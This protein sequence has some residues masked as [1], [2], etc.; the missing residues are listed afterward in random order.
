MRRGNAFPGPLASTDP[1]SQ[2]SL[3]QFITGAYAG[4]RGDPMYVHS[5][6]TLAGLVLAGA[7]VIQGCQC[8][9]SQARRNYGEIG[10]V[11][12]D[13]RDNV[14][15][16]RDATFDFGTLPLGQRIQKKLI[17]KNLGGGALTLLS[18]ER[19][20][21][22]EVIIGTEGDDAAPFE[23]RFVPDTSVGAQETVEFDMFFTPKAT[24]GAQPGEGFLVK[25]A[26]TAGGTRDGEDTATITLQGRG[27]AGTC[28]LPSSIDF[29]NVAVGSHGTRSVDFQNGSAADTE[30]FVGVI[31]SDTGDH[32]TFGF[33]P[34][35]PTGAFAISAGA[36]RTVGL[37]FRPAETRAYAAKVKM[38]AGSACGE[39]EVTLF[40][41]G[42]DEVLAWTPTSL[43]FQYVSPGTEAVKMITFTNHGSA[44]VE[45][46]DV[47]TSLPSD[48]GVKGAPFV[49]PG[50]GERQMPVVCKPT[51][52]GARS[53]Q[54]TFSTPIVKQPSGTIR[55]TCYG[56]GPDIQVMP[57]PTLNFGKTAYFSNS[58]PSY[59]VTRRLT[60]T[61]VGTAPPDGSPDGNLR[62]GQISA[63]GS[64]GQLPFVAIKALNATTAASEISV[65]IPPSY[66]PSVG[67]EALAGRNRADLTVTLTPNSIGRKEAELTIYSNDP[68]EPET[69]IVITSD[70]V[71]MPPCDYTVSP[72]KVSF[73]LVTPGTSRDVPVTFRNNGT[74]P[75][76]RCLI[77]GVDLTP[78]TDPSY[79]MP[80]GAVPSHELGPGETLQV[81]VR[82]SPQGTVPKSVVNLTGRLQYH[83]SSQTNPSGTVALDTQVGPSCLTIAPAHL[84]F[85]AVKPG[86]N[87]STR[88]FAI[89]NIC[90]QTVTL[91]RFAMI[92][93]AGQQPG[94]PNCAGAAACPEF[95]LVQTPAV[96][97]NGLSLPPGSSPVNFQAKYRPLDL[98]KDSG[99]IGVDVVQGGIS[100]TYLVTL[101]GRGEASGLNTDTFVQDQKPKADVLF[102]IDDSCSMDVHQNNLANNFASFMAY[103]QSANVDWQIGVTTT[104]MDDAFTSPLPGIPGKAD[105]AKGRLLG[106]ANNPKILTP[107]TPDVV[108]KFRAKV[109]VGSNGSGIEQGLE[110]SL[111]ALTPPLSV[112][113]NADFIRPDANLA[114]VVVTDAV[115]QSGRPASYYVNSFLNI[116]G[117]NKANMFTFNAIAGFNPRPPSSCAYDEG[118]DDGTYATVV[119]QTNGLRGE[120]CTTNWSA[121]LQGLGQTAFGFRTTFFLTSVPDTARPITVTVNGANVPASSGGTT[122][123]RYDPV[124]NAIVFDPASAPGPGEAME[125]AYYA[126]CVP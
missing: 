83:A 108:N 72:A 63:T 39:S 79:S 88:T 93:G 90:P 122:H 17:V 47:A 22:N 96:P 14:V 82:V 76:E 9:R 6:R 13:D 60:V 19:L 103:A 48:F 12:H 56:G 3:P 97:A 31:T 81:L 102:T 15:T 10:I 58:N 54:L 64:P 49:V 109:N 20:E 70:A 18:M 38:R 123:W 106:D 78:G 114:V 35:S 21:G 126:G 1:S 68:D 75:G 119:Q 16:A 84:D 65:G 51:Q 59:S 69:K 25:L 125:I 28:Q 26:L 118:P 5:F 30:A 120:I 85:G 11:H 100:V 43:D 115:D 61:N 42:V 2:D 36:A 124:S 107:T 33:A 52:L 45:L 95:H 27:S 46:F 29:G 87:S 101:E 37:E 53:G 44:D 8:D 34:S 66:Q 67:L 77:S 105:G 71:A 41:R 50:N 89:Y 74:A 99:V 32:Q 4:G 91:R 94:G 92:D 80:Q 98:G 40:G 23:V 112:N 7:V 110:P 86:C 113:E 111:R 121:T 104:D 55:L 117:F 57:S 62:L 73:G 116:K 24:S